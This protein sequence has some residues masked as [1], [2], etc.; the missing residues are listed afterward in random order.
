MTG[1]N[2]YR[3]AAIPDLE[4][5]YLFGDFCSGWLW[6]SWRDHDLQWHTTALLNTAY[7]ISSFGEDEAGEVYLI[8]YGGALYR[9][10]AAEA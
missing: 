5:V 4:A 3:G 8:D 9:F 10:D 7:E 6:A 1:G 2:V